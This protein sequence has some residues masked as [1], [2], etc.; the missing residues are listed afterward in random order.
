MQDFKGNAAAPYA[1]VDTDGT[2]IIGYYTLSGASVTL[3]Q[4]PPAV[5]KR[6]PRYPQI[7]AI[8][9][10]RLAVDDR[11]LR[12]RYGE[13]LLMDALAR[14]GNLAS[15]AGF[16]FVVVDA[17]DDEASAFYQK[18]GFEPFPDT[19][20]SLYMPMQTVFTLVGRR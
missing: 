12:R 3:D 5:G 13:A 17:K 18:Y 4:I 16:A 11:F 1:L 19:P 8:R 9:I 20:S 6:I 14:I 15:S 2:T 10:G 7:G